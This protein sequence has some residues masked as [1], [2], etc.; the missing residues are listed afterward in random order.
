MK[1]RRGLR[2]NGYYQYCRTSGMRRPRNRAIRDLLPASPA[3]LDRD[4]YLHHGRETLRPTVEGGIS[5]IGRS[6]IDTNIYKKRVLQRT[7]R[8]A[9]GQEVAIAHQW[10]L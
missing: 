3:R 1:R 8:S 6:K 10:P 4:P 9:E 2:S 5:N 7:S